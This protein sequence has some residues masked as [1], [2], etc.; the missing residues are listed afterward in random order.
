MTLPSDRPGLRIGV[1]LPLFGFAGA[2]LLTGADL[3]TFL[4]ECRR[5]GIREYSASDHIHFPAPWLDGFVGLS[6]AAALVP[7]AWVATTACLPVLR[8]PA[9]TAKMLVAL[10]RT[11]DRGALAG[12]CEGSSAADYRVAGIPISERRGRFDDA[13]RLTRAAL[14]GKDSFQGE[15]YQLEQPLRPAS[16]GTVELWLATWGGPKA[17]NLASEVGDGLFL[18]GMGT[19]SIGDMGR[20]VELIRSKAERS[21]RSFGVGVSTCFF[22]VTETVEE[23]KS[24]LR[25]LGDF[26]KNDPDRLADTLVVG[27]VEHCASQIAR[28]AQIGVELLYLLPV[29]NYYKHLAVLNESILPMLNVGGVKVSF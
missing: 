1:H 13:A 22:V 21:Q 29:G 26:V 23:G 4:S 27:T 14:E 8:G 9:V 7:G 2:G 19:S 20:T 28:Y 16:D 6:Y 3:R 24:F 11:A 15:Y 12:I 10:G 5:L 17:L 25:E 18:S